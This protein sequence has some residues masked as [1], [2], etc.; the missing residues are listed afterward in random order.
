MRSHKALRQEENPH[1]PNV[2]LSAVVVLSALFGLFGPNVGRLKEKRNTSG[3]ALALEDKDPEVQY[4][5]AEALGDLGEETS[6]A[7]LIAAMTRSEFSGVRWKAA[8]ALSKI[9]DPAVGQLIT[10]LQH[11][12]DD[13]RWQAAIALGEIGHPDAIE[14]LIALMNDG[15]R[16]VRSR[17]ANA[18]GLIGRPAVHRL[19]EV[20]KE[21]VVMARCGAAAALGQTGDPDAIE[22]LIRSLADHETEV[23]VEA[24][25][26]LGAIGEPATAS[27]IKFLKYTGGELRVE[28][29]RALGQLNAS[30]AL[31]PLIQIL[32]RAGD[33]E[34]QEVADALDTIL[35]PEA[36][37]MVE[38][39]RNGNNNNNRKGIQTGTE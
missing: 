19:N 26:A 32:E 35:A 18:L 24:A 11:T 16:Y 38:R 25:A 36:A 23:R 28:V 22:P 20:L 15:D 8:E 39:I 17:A 3:L 13:V 34:R 37:P 33:R 30:E 29:V 2:L 27:L 12:D 4:R 7:P 14:P 9:G 31:E 6:V 21:G 1:P 5:A 10:L